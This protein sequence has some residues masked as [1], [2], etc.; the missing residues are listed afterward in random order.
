MLELFRD[1]RRV[2]NMH[3]AQEYAG[4]VE[5]CIV[6]EY[7]VNTIYYRIVQKRMNAVKEYARVVY[8]DSRRI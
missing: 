2:C 8:R 4:V 5:V 7:T 6:E 3:V 1:S